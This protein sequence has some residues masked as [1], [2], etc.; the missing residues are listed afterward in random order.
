MVVNI[1]DGVGVAAT[2]VGA[3]LAHRCASNATAGSSST[4]ASVARRCFRFTGAVFAADGA[5]VKDFVF[6]DAGDPEPPDPQ[7]PSRFGDRLGRYA[8]THPLGDAFD[9]APSFPHDEGLLDPLHLDRT[10]TRFAVFVGAGTFAGSTAGGD[11]VLAAP[12]R[13]PACSTRASSSPTRPGPARS[14]S[15]SNG[16][17]ARRSPC[18]CGC[19]PR[20]PARRRELVD[21]ARGGPAAARPPPRGGRPRVR[22]V[23]RSALGARH[24][25][26]CATSTATTRS[27]SSSPAPAPGRTTA[28]NPLPALAEPNP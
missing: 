9:A 13:S 10:E 7:H 19:P 8:V 23:R 18:G 14:R 21:A 2:F 4:A 6:A 5:H 25:R 20:S 3:R 16:T 22:R 11:V 28:R 15:A 27:A 1:D 24:R 17:S 26:A 12:S